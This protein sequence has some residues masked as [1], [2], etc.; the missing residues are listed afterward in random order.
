MLILKID[1]TET[2]TLFGIVTHRQSRAPYKGAGP[3]TGGV[4]SN[5]STENGVGGARPLSRRER[6]QSLRRRPTRRKGWSLLAS[7]GRLIGQAMSIK[8]LAGMTLF[9]LVGAVLPFCLG[10][11]SPPAD[12]SPAGDTL[13]TWQPK[14]GGIADAGRF[15]PRPKR[16]P[17]PSHAGR[18]CGFPPLP[19]NCRRR[20]RFRQRPRPS[21]SRRQP[22]RLPSR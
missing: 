10:Q 6:G 4:L 20:R 18:R 14:R 15:L 7:S 11:K 17:R 3:P 21:A 8:L 5:E 12:P 22:Q 13:S 2:D 19:T 1:A 16:S 9:L